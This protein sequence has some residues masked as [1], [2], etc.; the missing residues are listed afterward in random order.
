MARGSPQ[1]QAA[2]DIQR[3]NENLRESYGRNDFGQRLLLA[4]RLV[5]V[6]VSFVTVYNG[7]EEKI[8]GTIAYLER[9]FDVKAVTKKDAAIPVDVVVTVGRNTPNLQ[10]PPSS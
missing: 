5:E 4:R 1:A 10:P 6:G 7:A 9:L 3:E 8:P 2:F